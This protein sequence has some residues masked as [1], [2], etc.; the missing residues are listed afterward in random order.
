MNRPSHLEV[1]ASRANVVRGA[2]SETLTDC[3]GDE[4]FE[5]LIERW[6]RQAFDAYCAVRHAQRQQGCDTSLRLVAL[7]EAAEIA[8]ALAEEIGTLR[9]AVMLDLPDDAT[10][11]VLA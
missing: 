3:R 2:F 8:V 11:A 6:R 7:C 5:A 1:L 9:A 4:A 10:H